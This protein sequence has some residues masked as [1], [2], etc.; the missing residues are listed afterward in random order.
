[1]LWERFKV[2]QLFDVLKPSCPWH[3]GDVFDPDGNIT[4]GN[5]RYHLDAE[6]RFP[7]TCGR[8]REERRLGY[9]ATR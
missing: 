7:C 9:P 6:G 3:T 8:L 1:M 5:Y 4:I 2:W